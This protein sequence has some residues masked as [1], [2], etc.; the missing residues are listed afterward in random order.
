MRKNT[1]AFVRV[2][3]FTLINMNKPKNI[4]PFIKYDTSLD[5]F[6]YEFMLKIGYFLSKIL[7]YVTIGVRE[8]VYKLQYWYTKKRKFIY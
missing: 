4:Y 2:Q 3:L 5:G 8:L 7:D 6:L 1:L